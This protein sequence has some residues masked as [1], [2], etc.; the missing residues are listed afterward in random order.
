MLTSQQKREI[1]V[2]EYEVA[3]DAPKTKSVLYLRKKYYRRIKEPPWM[4]H[5][6]ALNVIPGVI[7]AF[8]EEAL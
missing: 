2:T 3:Q 7:A 5:G 4:K 1:T 6:L 8:D